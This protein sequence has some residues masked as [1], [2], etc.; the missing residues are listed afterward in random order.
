MKQLG[1]IF[2]ILGTSIGVGMLALPTVTGSMGFFYSIGFFIAVSVCMLFTAFCYIDI[3]AK[4]KENYT[5]IT[6]SKKYYGVSFSIV[7]M[8]LFVVLLYTLLIA[9]ISAMAPVFATVMPLWLS[10]AALPLLCLYPLIKGVKNLDRVNSIFVMFLLLTC[11]TLIISLLPDVTHS[12]L[13]HSSFDGFY[14]VLPV[15][16]TAFG[17]HIILPSI[18]AYLEYDKKK[19]K[20]CAAIGALCTTLLYILWQY[21][22][23]GV[24]PLRGE[25]SIVSSY[26]NGVP[27]VEAL[28]HHVSSSSV[29]LLVWLFSI[30][31]IVTS[32]LGVALSL[33]DSFDQMIPIKKSSIRRLFAAVGALLPPMIIASI[34][35]SIFLLSI[36]Y[37]GSIVAILLL[38]IPLSLHVKYLKEER[39]NVPYLFYS[40][41]FFFG[42]AI[43]ACNVYTTAHI[44]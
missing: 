29:S 35:P 16:I 41:L 15:V 38:I 33:I 10:Q 32:F 19:M 17:Y 40:L 8:A 6:L 11:S 23:L 24:V 9:Y 13:A 36:E 4:H 43:V 12:Y 21:A 22:V 31:A 25:Y 5:L 30:S 14:E 44:F 34:S 42:I 1:A 20:Q 27:I 28:S 37:A 7:T 2:F 26:T 3:I 18:G 39:R